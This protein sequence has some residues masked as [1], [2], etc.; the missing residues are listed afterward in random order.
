MDHLEFEAVNGEEQEEALVPQ[1]KKY[2]F[3]AFRVNTK[4]F[5]FNREEANQRHAGQTIEG[6]LN[7]FEEQRKVVTP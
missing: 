4:D 6:I 2:V 7:P 3:E 1:K 5:K